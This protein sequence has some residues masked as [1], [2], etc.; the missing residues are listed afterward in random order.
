MQR[1]FL[2]FQNSFTIF[3]LYFFIQASE[4]QVSGQRSEVRGIIISLYYPHKLIKNWRYT[5]PSRYDFKTQHFT[6]S[7]FHALFL[8][9]GRANMSCVLCSEWQAA[10]RDEVD[11]GGSG[12]FNE[13]S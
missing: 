6:V 3:C 13:E 10:A 7:Q 8:Q 4:N 2:S 11:K 1:N 5:K 9:T 12:K